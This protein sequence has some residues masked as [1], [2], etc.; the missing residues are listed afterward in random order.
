MAAKGKGLKW[1]IVGYYGVKG[2]FGAHDNLS[3]TEAQDHSR[4]NKES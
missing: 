4:I 1:R 3:P 2:L